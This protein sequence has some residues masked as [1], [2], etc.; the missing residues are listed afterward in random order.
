MQTLLNLTLDLS[1]SLVKKK[2]TYLNR[3][4]GKSLSYLYFYR[5]VNK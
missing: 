1:F 4:F 3:K 5:E 2:L